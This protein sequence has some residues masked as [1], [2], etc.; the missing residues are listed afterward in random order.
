MT[1]A[2]LLASLAFSAVGPTPSGPPMPYLDRGACPFECCTYQDWTATQV[3]AVLKERRSTSAV[4]F[5]LKAGDKAHAVTGVV[6][7][8]VPGII[9]I[10][11]AITVGEKGHEIRLRPGDR[12]YML[13]YQGEG[14]GLFWFN[15]SPFSDQFWSDDLG[16]VPGTSA[17]E[18]IQLPRTIWWIKIRNSLGQTGWTQHPEHYD[19]ADGC[20]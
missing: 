8:T 20:A 11:E 4:L 6:V 15:G 3:T 1:L 7:T 2:F 18:V 10:H 17:F 5:A 14:F 13:H 12:V 16:M 9:K 19:G